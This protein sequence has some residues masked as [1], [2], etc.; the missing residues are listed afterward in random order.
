M[1]F[2]V[3]HSIIRAAG[4]PTFRRLVRGSW[5]APLPILI[6]RVQKK[7]GRNP[8]VP[9]LNSSNW[10][11]GVDLN[12]RPSGY[13]PDELPGCSTPHIQYNGRFTF[14]QMRG[15]EYLERRLWNL[16]TVVRFAVTANLIRARMHIINSRSRLLRRENCVADVGDPIFLP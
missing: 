13:E 12:Q 2:S 16:P 9:A 5:G 1:K 3:Y 4:C 15:R 14:R 11:R 7:K 6:F 8:A 10:L